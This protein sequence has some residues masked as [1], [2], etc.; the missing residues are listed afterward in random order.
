MG[1]EQAFVQHVGPARAHEVAARPQ[2]ERTAARAFRELRHHRP[3]GVP[4]HQQETEALREVQLRAA[5]RGG[6]GPREHQLA[7]PAQVVA[8]R[9][10]LRAGQGT[11]GRAQRR[12]VGVTIGLVEH[13][14][15]VAVAVRS[16]QHA[17]TPARA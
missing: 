12:G 2:A 16:A 14:R 1:V 7:V 17:R 13:D 9:G 4:A 15:T 3:V 6:V 10:V 11:A 5:L 8:E